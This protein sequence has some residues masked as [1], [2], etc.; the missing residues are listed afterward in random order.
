MFIGKTLSAPA[1]GKRLAW[2]A[3]DVDV[4]SRCFLVL[5]LGDVFVNHFWIK[6]TLDEVSNVFV[7]VARKRV[8]KGYLYIFEGLNLGFQPATVSADL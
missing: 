1:Q 5:S 7:D 6:V 8:R 3:R 2:K 4:H